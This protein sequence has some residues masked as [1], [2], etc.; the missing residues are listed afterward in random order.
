[1]RGYGGKCSVI[2]GRVKA[3]TRNPVAPGM[4]VIANPKIVPFPY[5]SS[6]YGGGRIAV[7]VTGIYP[8]EA[9]PVTIKARFFTAEYAKE[10]KGNR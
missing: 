1:M 2:P 8:C 9:I 5:S 7:G 4:I 3:M 6:P 10:R